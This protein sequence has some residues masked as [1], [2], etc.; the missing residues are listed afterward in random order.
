MERNQARAE[1]RS[2]HPQRNGRRGAPYPVE[3]AE[4]PTFPEWLRMDIEEKKE[5][6]IEIPD[7]VDDTSRPPSLQAQRFKSMYAYGYH[8]RV[9]SAEET[10]TKT[11]DSG[12]AAF[13]RRPCRSGRHN[14]NLV[15]AN[16]EYIGQI[17]EIV[18][19]NYGR[20]CTV[21][22]VCEWVKANYRGRS[23][24]V[25]KDEWG[26]TL[27]NF[28]NMVPFGYESFSFPVH[29]DQVFFSDEEDEPGWK[30]VLRTEVRGR[31]IDN[32]MEDPDEHPMFSMGSDYDFEGL[33]VPESIPERNPDPLPTG[34]NIQINEIINAVVEEEAVVFDRDIGESSEEEG[35]YRYAGL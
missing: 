34:R 10:I 26:F 1:F 18:E 35:E 21:L 15:E 20:H 12:V 11:C 24:T 9:K 2:R 33:R 13:F 17:L 7:E 16:L 25:R 22:L 30:V 5:Q 32:E 3:L 28:N 8:Y 29:C 19:L 14:E 23:A 6:G 4:L 27:A 31:R